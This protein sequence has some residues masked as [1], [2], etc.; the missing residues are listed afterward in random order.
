MDTA[1]AMAHAIEALGPF[2]TLPG[3]AIPVFAFRVRDADVPYD[4]FDLSREL[5]GRGW[6]VPAYTL[7]PDVSDVA[8]LRVVIRNGFSADLGELFLADLERVMAELATQPAHHRPH[9]AAF[10]H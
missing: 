2:Q 5:R 1:R 8:V 9:R 7:P 4:V 10:H 6:Q 3:S